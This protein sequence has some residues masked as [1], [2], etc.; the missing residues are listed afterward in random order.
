M[1][2]FFSMVCGSYCLRVVYDAGPGGNGSF[3]ISKGNASRHF[4]VARDELVV[5]SASWR[6]KLCDAKPGHY[7]VNKAR[8]VAPPLESA[9]CHGGSTSPKAMRCLRYRRHVYHFVRQGGTLGVRTRPRVAFAGCPQVESDAGTHRTPKALCAKTIANNHCA[10]RSRMR[11][12][13]YPRYR[14]TPG[15]GSGSRSGSR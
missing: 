5:A 13:A 14:S 15:C 6:A 2:V 4:E 9:H 11:R 10:S 7:Y 1:S 12:W 8:A 3:L